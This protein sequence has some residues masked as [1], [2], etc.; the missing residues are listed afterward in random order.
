MWSSIDRQG[1]DLANPAPIRDAIRTI[2]PD[3]MVN[4]AA[5]TAV[6]SAENKTELAFAIN[7]TAPGVMARNKPRLGGAI[8][9]YLHRLCVRRHKNPNTTRRTSPIRYR[10][11]GRTK[12]DGEQGV[13]ASGHPAFDFPHQL[14]LLLSVRELLSDDDALVPAAQ[15][16]AGG[17]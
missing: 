17:R 15:G 12:L 14:G 10:V 9:H 7:A 16:I 1:M 11:Y 8:I 4:A 2:Q 6:D 13:A 5:Y 3:L